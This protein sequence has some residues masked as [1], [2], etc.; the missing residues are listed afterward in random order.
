LTRAPWIR[1]SIETAATWFEFFGTSSAAKPCGGRSSRGIMDADIHHFRW[2]TSCGHGRTSHVCAMGWLQ[3]CLMWALLLIP[4][5]HARC[6]LYATTVGSQPSAEIQN[7][8]GLR[9]G[10][11]C[12][13][14]E[15]CVTRA[16]RRT[17]GPTVQR[18]IVRIW[19]SVRR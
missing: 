6:V 18:C 14:A 12:G 15:E 16:F 10:A 4:L 8:K 7:S 11:L 5:A 1:I 2:N 17:R 19:L 13:G 3:G 9:G